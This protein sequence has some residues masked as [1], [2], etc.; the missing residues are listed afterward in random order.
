MMAEMSENRVGLQTNLEEEKSKQS[1]HKESLKGIEAKFKAQATEMNEIQQNLDNSTK[2]FAEFEKKDV[3]FRE[4]LKHMKQQV[5]K[6]DEKLA[7]ESAK[8]KNRR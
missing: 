7:K 1:E 8:G 4:D 3:K 6:L 5:K 2:E